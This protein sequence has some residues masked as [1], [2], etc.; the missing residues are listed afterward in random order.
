V[1]KAVLVV[2]AHAIGKTRVVEALVRE[3]VKRKHRVGTVKHITEKEFTI[4]HPGK[5]TWVHAKAGA[6]TVV[7]MAAGETAW[8]VKHRE[9]LHDVVKKIQDVDFVIVE[10]FRSFK[11]LP[12]IV[13]ATEDKKASEL[14]DEFA[15]AVVGVPGH[16]I[17]SF[18]FKDVSALADLVEQ[19]AAVISGKAKPE[20]S[21]TSRTTVAVEVD[22]KTL[23]LNPFVQE[24]VSKTIQGM[25]ASLRGDEG[26]TIVI[27]VIKHD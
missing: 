26:K 11:G 27:K 22:G 21:K 25:V 10:G 3:L 7:S 9:E 20:E 12:K 8:I 18:S 4:D 24:I 5:D 17:P 1:T 14:V 23:P 19:K 16:G 15:I 13:V 2:G 6:S